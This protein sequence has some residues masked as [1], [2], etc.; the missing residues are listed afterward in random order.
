MGFEAGYGDTGWLINSSL[1]FLSCFQI[2]PCIPFFY[3]AEADAGLARSLAPPTKGGATTTAATATAATVGSA[4][5]SA[6]A[7]L[8][9]ALDPAQLLLNQALGGALGGAAAGGAADLGPAPSKT[10]RTKGKGGGRGKQP[11][12]STAGAGKSAAVLG[13]WRLLLAAEPADAPA[14]ASNDPGS[15]AAAA[16]A[17]LWKLYPIVCMTPAEAVTHLPA[18]LPPNLSPPQA[19]GAPLN[20][21][22]HS[23][24][25]VVLFDEASQLPTL[26]ALPCIGR[27]KQVSRVETPQFDWSIK[28]HCFLPLSFNVA[29]LVVLFLFCC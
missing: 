26:E 23:P 25:D 4:G 15:G 19:G 12:V 10:P 11:A 17:L 21:C 20:A 6:A 28:S 7:L 14:L 24:F 5:G 9:T 16:L 29:I 8:A 2:K 27:A 18:A 3:Q 1:T 22:S 13:L